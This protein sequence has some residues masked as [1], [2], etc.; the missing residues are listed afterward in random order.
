MYKILNRQHKAQAFMMLFLFLFT[1]CYRGSSGDSQSSPSIFPTERVVIEY[2]DWLADGASVSWKLDPGT[3]R[4]ELTANNDGATA[5]WVGANCPKTQPMR[6]LSMT[7]EMPRTGQLIIT[8]PTRLGLGA[9]VSVTVKVT[10][11]S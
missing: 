3:Y 7:C 5:E 2:S 9:K 6:E 10:K 1:G 4:L 8:N 11:L